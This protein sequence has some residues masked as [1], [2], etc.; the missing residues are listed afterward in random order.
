MFRSHTKLK[1]RFKRKNVFHETVVHKWDF[2]TIH[3]HLLY[4]IPC[5]LNTRYRFYRSSRDRKQ[6]H[7]FCCVIEYER[8]SG[9]PS[10]WKILYCNLLPLIC[11]ANLWIENVLGINSAQWMLSGSTISSNLGNYAVIIDG[12]NFMAAS[13][14]SLG[15]WTTIWPNFTFWKITFLMV[16]PTPSIGILSWCL[17][18]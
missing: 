3:S 12:T 11:R 1:I 4:T 7:Q 14:N 17:S 6:H 8:Y 15:V 13:E 2:V 9:L 18:L 5:T 10:S 16:P